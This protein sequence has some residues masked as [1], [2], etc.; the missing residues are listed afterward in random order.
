VKKFQIKP[1]IT[2]QQTNLKKEPIYRESVVSD[3]VIN[4]TVTQNRK[5]MGTPNF[6]GGAYLNFAAT[7]K[8]NFNVSGYYYSNYRYTNIYNLLYN[9]ANPNPDNN[10][11]AANINGKVL[12]NAKT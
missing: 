10:M 3:S 11:G 4:I 5:D 1:F 12:I 2:I 8:L 7:S 6:Y 9:G